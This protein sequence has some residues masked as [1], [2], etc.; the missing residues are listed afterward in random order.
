MRAVALRVPC[1]AVVEVAVFDEL[2]EDVGDEDAECDAEEGRGALGH[3]LG[4]GEFD[5][6]ADADR[7]CDY[8]CQ[9]AELHESEV[10]CDT[11]DETEEEDVP[12]CVWGVWII[13]KE[14]VEGDA[15]AEPE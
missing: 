13:C 1:A 15:R 12:E 6:E 7:E 4:Y 9:I 2:G 14:L 11:L 8:E 5:D 3:V 10:E